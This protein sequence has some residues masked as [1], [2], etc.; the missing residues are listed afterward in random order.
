[1]DT[2]ENCKSVKWRNMMKKLFTA[3]LIST[4]LSKIV[5]GF[6]V[7]DKLYIPLDD[8]LYMNILEVNII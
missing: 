5:T 8:N 3:I 6:N 2:L 4:L 1:M 7:F